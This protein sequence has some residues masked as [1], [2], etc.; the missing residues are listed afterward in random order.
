MFK[1]SSLALMSPTSTPAPWSGGAGDTE[2]DGVLKLNPL[3]WPGVTGR[4][5]VLDLDL[6][7]VVSTEGIGTSGPPWNKNSWLSAD[8]PDGET[9]SNGEGER[10]RTEPATVD[11]DGDG[12]GCVGGSRTMGC[13]VER[14]L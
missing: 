2:I 11:G 13:L 1:L 9:N 7:L 12:E 6:D 8:D 4:A 14:L 10:D 5:E 3:D